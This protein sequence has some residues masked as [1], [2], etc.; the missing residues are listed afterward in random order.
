MTVSIAL[1]Y[2]ADGDIV[3]DMVLQYAEIMAQRGERNLGPIGASL[4]A[5]SCQSSSQLLDNNAA[6]Q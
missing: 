3:A 2:G 1:H 5:R 6:A 4:N